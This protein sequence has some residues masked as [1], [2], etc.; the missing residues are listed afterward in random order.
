MNAWIN[1]QHDWGLDHHRILKIAEEKL[2]SLIWFFMA[3]WMTLG[4]LR[5]AVCVADSRE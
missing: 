4:S 3:L 5:D 1:Q 2:T